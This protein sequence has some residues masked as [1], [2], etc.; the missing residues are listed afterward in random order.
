MPLFGSR[1][2]CETANYKYI[3]R[4]DNNF[5]KREN[6]LKRYALFFNIFVHLSIEKKNIFASL[7]LKIYPK[8]RVLL[9]LG[10]IFFSCD[11]IV[12]FHAYKL[13]IKIKCCA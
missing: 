11:S 10:F 8:P 3:E 7:I 6:A 9:N 2:V 12:L 1:M 5:G 4:R 13:K